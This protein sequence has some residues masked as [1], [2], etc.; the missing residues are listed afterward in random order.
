[1]LRFLHYGWE[2]HPLGLSPLPTNP[3][4]WG[5]DQPHFP[6]FQPLPPA[7]ASSVETKTTGEG[8]GPEISQRRQTAQ[9]L[10]GKQKA[11][12]AA[13]P[14]GALTRR[15]SAG[16]PPG[17][18]CKSPGVCGRG[19]GLGSCGRWFRIHPLSSGFPMPLFRFPRGLPSRQG[20]GGGDN[21]EKGFFSLLHLTS[22]GAH[23]P[24]L[25]ELPAP[26]WACPLA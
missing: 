15:P 7:A 26:L 9:S 3:A 24:P 25:P 11:Q 13:L 6:V 21:S 22:G 18:V 17:R 20:G 4:A 19:G 23:S 14:G 16:L 12:K 8:S 1:M 10:R 2:R 5:K